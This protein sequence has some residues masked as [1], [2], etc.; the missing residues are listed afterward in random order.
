MHIS[1]G[2]K[3]TGKVAAVERAIREYSLFHGST[4]EVHDVESLVS[5]MPVGLDEI[6]SGAKNRARWA[7]E[8]GEYDIAFGIESGIFPVPHT[9]SGYIDTTSC[10]IYDGTNY[11]IGLS[12]CFEYPKGMAEGVINHGK[13]ISDIAVEMGFSE[14]RNFKNGLGM[15]GVLTKGRMTR[16]D[17]TYQA[18]Q[19]CMVYLENPECY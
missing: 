12:S 11:H 18:V 5:G 3:N 4:L 14:D 13:E 15:I 16:I 2:T 10:V 19:M 7:Y 1:I 9:K 17:Y 8:K 6:I